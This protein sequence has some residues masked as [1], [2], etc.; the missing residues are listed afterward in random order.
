MEN[1]VQ[2]GGWLDRF[3][4]GKLIIKYYE[5]FGTYYEEEIPPS[6]GFTSKAMA[7]AGDLPSW[8]ERYEGKSGKWT[9]VNGQVFDVEWEE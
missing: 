4:R 1:S 5:G 2:F 7:E 9:I 3:E 6:V 8:L